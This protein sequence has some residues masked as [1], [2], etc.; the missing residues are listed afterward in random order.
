[1]EDKQY[2]IIK[3]VTKGGSVSYKIMRKIGDSDVHITT[4]FNID[5]ARN[6]IHSLLD[7]EVIS[8]EIVE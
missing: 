8:S 6:V 1:M 5:N 4:R 2:Y 7:A 3:E